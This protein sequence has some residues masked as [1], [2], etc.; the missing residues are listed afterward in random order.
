MILM[1]NMHFMGLEFRHVIFFLFFL[2]FLI[3]FWKM[4]K[5]IV[6]RI[7]LEMLNNLGLPEYVIISIRI[8][9]PGVI[10]LCHTAK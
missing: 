10:K 2:I 5:F 1:I 4:D 3:S 7:I 8:H 6:A 9:S